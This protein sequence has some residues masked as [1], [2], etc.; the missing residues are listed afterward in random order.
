MN[1]V[2]ATGIQGFG[3]ASAAMKALNAGSRVKLGAFDVSAENPDNLAALQNG[4]AVFVIDQQPFLQGYDAVQVA[5]FQARFGQHPFRPVYT[6]PSLVTKDNAAK[7]QELYQGLNTTGPPT[8][9]NVAMVTHG[10]G[11]DPFWALIR[12][13]AEQAAADFDVDLACRWPDTPPHP[14]SRPS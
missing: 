8:K 5:A 7:V 12:K 2:L 9:I 14:P 3:A 1:G 13:G 11:F 6:G 4:E 10:Q